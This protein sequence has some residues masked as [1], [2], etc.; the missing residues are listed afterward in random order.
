MKLQD[1][2]T[3]EELEGIVKGA[4]INH[5]EITYGVDTSLEDEDD[6]KTETNNVSNNNK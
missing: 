5:Q 3:K 6:T 4:G 2:L 1:Y